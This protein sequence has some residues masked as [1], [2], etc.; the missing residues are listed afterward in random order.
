MTKILHSAFSTTLSNYRFKKNVNQENY[1][2][3]QCADMVCSLELIKQRQK[4]N[5]HIKAVEN[6]F[7]SE[8][9]FNKNYGKA[10]NA[11]EL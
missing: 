6:F 2:I 8:R 1:R 5:E 4:N 3:L 10:Y 11:L 7:I 9:K